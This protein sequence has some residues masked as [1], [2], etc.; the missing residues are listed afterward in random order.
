MTFGTLV[1]TKAGGTTLRPA[2]S[3]F[4]AVVMLFLEVVGL[5]ALLILSAPVLSVPELVPGRVRN[6]SDSPE[7]RLEERASVPIRLLFTEP[8]DD[9][10]LLDC[11]AYGDADFGEGFETTTG[12]PFTVCARFPSSAEW[13]ITAMETIDRWT[14]DGTA[15]QMTLLDAG[16][17][18]EVRLSDDST[19][20]QLS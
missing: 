10:F 1:P 16:L 12:E 19:R 15:V 4:H 17:G 3:A 7:G 8:D 18:P 14:A 5:V 20:L 9:G 11:V 13:V 6:P 2:R